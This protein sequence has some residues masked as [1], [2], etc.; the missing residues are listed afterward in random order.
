MNVFPIAPA[1]SRYLWFLVPV[2]AILVGAATLLVLS[3]RGS[4]AATFEIRPDGLAL[5]GDLYGRFLPRVQLQV[6]MA[7]RVDWSQDDGLRPQWRPMGTRLLG[8]PPPDMGTQSTTFLLPGSPA[9]PGHQWMWRFAFG[10]T[11]IPGAPT[12][13][14]YVT[15]LGRVVETEPGNLQALLKALRP[16]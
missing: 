7:R 15:P 6:A 12:V 14:I 8:E 11:R 4:R 13:R 5:H 3:V 10:P 9:A 2:L 16:Y 1:A